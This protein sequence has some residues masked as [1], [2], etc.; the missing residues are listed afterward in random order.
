VNKPAEL[1]I[2][3]LTLSGRAVR[4]EPMSLSHLEG[5]WEAGTDPEIW[6]YMPHPVRSK[7]EMRSYIEDAQRKEAEGTALPFTQ[8]EASTGRVIGSTRYGNI[9]K[10]DRRVEI[11]WTW[12]AQPWQRSAMNT[13]SKYLLMR[14]AFETLGCIRVEL[15]TDSLNEKSRKAIARIGAKEE[16]TLRNHII[17][18]DGRIRHTVYFSVIAGEWPGV[19]TRLQLL[20]KAGTG[21]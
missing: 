18:H 12:L 3:P 14:H 15:K 7:E 17:C 6:K 13:E 16:G 10:A 9:S 8:L 4:L 11:G 1:D 21:E 5:L 19:K 20:M 2:K